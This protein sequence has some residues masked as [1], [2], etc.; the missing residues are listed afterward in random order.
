MKTIWFHRFLFTR[1]HWKQQF[2]D[3]W[4]KIF[5]KKSFSSSFLRDWRW[6]NPSVFPCDEILLFAQRLEA[7][8]FIIFPLFLSLSLSLLLHLWTSL[9]LYLSVTLFIKLRCFYSLRFSVVFDHISNMNFTS[10]DGKTIKLLLDLNNF[11]HV[12]MHFDV[13][14]DKIVMCIENVDDYFMTFIKSK[15][16]S[17]KIRCIVI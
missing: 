1:L 15:D 9:S 12:C 4:L 5:W 8:F 10:I 6:E 3:D 13:V 2:Y 17:I 7:F 11:A 16:R 14:I